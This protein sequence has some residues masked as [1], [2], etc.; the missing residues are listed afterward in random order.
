MHVCV[1]M[2]MRVFVQVR[3]CAC[4]CVRVCVY[5]RACVCVCAS[6][7]FLCVGLFVQVAARMRGACSLDSP[8]TSLCMMHSFPH[9]CE[10]P[11]V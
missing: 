4:V 11:A 3:V 10:A 8:K 1:F 6:Q 5:V 9:A 2:R 7:A